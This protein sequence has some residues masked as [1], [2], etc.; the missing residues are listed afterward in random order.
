MSV[1]IRMKMTGR[2]H[3]PFFRICVIDRQKARDGL[4]I[5]ELGTY[6]PMV[7]AKSDRVKVNMERIDYWLSVGATP[8]DRVATLLKKIKNNDFGAP[9]PAP[10]RVKPKELPVAAEA[11]AGEG[12][13]A[14][15]AEGGEASS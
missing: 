8:S 6:D 3:Q 10:E 4:P 15:P 1:R 11:P 14:A 9:A 13:E 7:K 2:K 5:E 12:G